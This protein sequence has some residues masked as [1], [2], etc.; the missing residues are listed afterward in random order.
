[1]ENTLRDR[2]LRK[3][4]EA[5]LNALRSQVQALEAFLNPNGATPHKVSRRRKALT[6]AE[7]KAISLRM[8]KYWAERRAKSK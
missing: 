8:K 1:M 6:A 7:R 4:A 3:G 2:L 5:E